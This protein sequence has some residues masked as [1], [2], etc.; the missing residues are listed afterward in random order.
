[1]SELSFE[2]RLARLPVWARD[3][4]ADLQRDL[5]AVIRR[6]QELEEERVTNLGA[7]NN[8]RVTWELLMEGEHGLPRYANVRFHIDRDHGVHVTMRWNESEDAIDINASEPLVIRPI[9]TNLIYL[10]TKGR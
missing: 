4:I 3:H 10:T 9:A 5:D 8:A 6:K 1:M 2:E 7:E